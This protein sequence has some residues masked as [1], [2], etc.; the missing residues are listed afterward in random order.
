VDEKIK[1]RMDPTAIPLPTEQKMKNAQVEEAAKATDTN[2]CR[3]RSR[4]AKRP[5][6]AREGMKNEKNGRWTR[7]NSTNAV[8]APKKFLKAKTSFCDEHC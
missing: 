5:S 6:A 2:R 8:T 3:G 7:E 1:W 4:Q